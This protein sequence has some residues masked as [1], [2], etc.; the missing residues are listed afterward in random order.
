MQLSIDIKAKEWL[1]VGHTENLREKGKDPLTPKISAGAK[2]VRGS[3]LSQRDRRVVIHCM[4]VNQEHVVSEKHSCF[5]IKS[6]ATTL[7]QFLAP[8]Q[9]GF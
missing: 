2:N 5:V 3:P 6:K 8:L 1:N 4:S 7:P 9:S